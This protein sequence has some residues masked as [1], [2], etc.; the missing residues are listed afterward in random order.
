M[1]A[2]FYVQDNPNL[3]QNCPGEIEVML[4]T[5]GQNILAAD[6]MMT[7]SSSEMTLSNMALGVALPM[8][9]YNVIAAAIL[10]LSGARLPATGSFNGN[11]LY[12]LLT[13]TP[14]AAATSITV[15]FDKSAPTNNVIANETFTNVIDLPNTDGRTI[16]VN[17]RY[18]EEVDGVGFC[19]PDLTPPT[20]NF[21][22]PS[23]GQGGVPVNQPNE[24]F[25]IAD[26][27]A[28]VDI[29]T[30]DY[31]IEGVNYDDT[32]AANTISELGGVHR[33]ETTFTS[34]WTEGQTVNISVYVCD[35]NT[36]PGP[37]CGTTNGTFH[38]YSTPPPSPVCGDGILTYT[39]GEQC[40]DGNNVD[41][42]G[43]SAH[44]FNEVEPVECPDCS[45]CGTCPSAGLVIVTE[46]APPFET[47][48]ISGVEEDEEPEIQEGE[49]PAV[50]QAIRDS[51]PGCT[52]EDIVEDV[53]REFN[54]D[55]RFGTKDARCLEDPEHCMLPFL[56]HS[57]YENV[58][59]NG[60]R[61]YPDVYL[62]GER[63]EP[64]LED[65]SG[66]ISG[67][68][69]EDIHLGTR[70]GMVHGFYED[71][72]NLSPYRPQWNMSRIEII[73]VLNWAVFGQQWKYENEYYA[74]IGGEQNLSSVKKLAADLIEWWHPRYYNLACEK[75]VFSCDPATSFEPDT[76]CSPTWKRD[77]FAR[78]KVFFEGQ[79][80]EVVNPDLDTDKDGIM[81]MDET[82][83][84]LTD[85]ENK[86][87]DGDTLTDGDEVYK[88]KSNPRLMDTDYD[89]LDDQDEIMIHKTSP[90]LPD[91]DGDEYWDDVEIENG[92]DPLDPNSHPQDLNGNGI[93]DEWELRYGISPQSGNDDTDGDG[94]SDLWEFKHNTDPT[95]PDTDGD[96][97]SDA[98]EVLLYGSDPL[99]F[100]NLA[101]LGV[102]ITN[103]VDGMTITDSRPFIQG[104]APQE[105]M[106][107][108]VL[109]RNE[110][111][112]EVM[113]GQ[114]TTDVNNA[115]VLT[116]DFDLVDGEFFLLV[117]GL[118]P[119]NK[120]V[121]ESPLIRLTLDSTLQIDSPRPERLSTINITDDIL[122]EGV[123]IEIRDSKP[124]LIGRAGFKNKVIATWQSVVGTSAIV[125]D[126]AGGEFKIS[127]PKELPFGK[128]TVTVYSVRESD[129]AVSKTV[130]LNFEVKEPLSGILRGVAFGEEL[131]FPVW[132]WILIF[133]GAGGIFMYGVWLDRKRK[134]KK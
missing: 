45:D 37:N 70:Q 119:K 31:T 87:T 116:P 69:K 105:G 68:A 107:V 113:L 65:D 118:D 16:T 58:D 121:L 85:F 103:L 112:H 81:D 88:Y 55:T 110:F 51:I 52:R 128:H 82:N 100:T 109:L 61:Y 114:V 22:L 106:E 94:L 96:G 54:V 17:D 53:V 26:N 76:V 86:D 131:I 41:G 6:A 34:E 91:T 102:R 123:S 2:R 97:L 29:T 130:V 12:G 84:F 39:N 44:C 23:N 117:K 9:T 4:D 35:N 80:S 19:S 15:D 75:G 77:I 28:G 73:K 90:I 21:I 133:L 63:S 66:A 124:I 134:G 60:D 89:N 47:I 43:C 129:Q 64:L 72:P 125:A 92:F 59:P 18:N 48:D 104:F 7:Y 13:V 49:Y 120:R 3:R 20:V 101:D 36:D 5:Q 10:E 42:D 98:D 62:S 57:A 78:Y 25:S 33:V 111:G 93:W 74:E 27:R 32:S 24:I 38:I 126:L 83:I 99:T 40:D 95:N 132:L 115:W 67:P 71:I 8:Q 14:D 46:T 122:L 108:E 11:G 50:S 30:L 127:A 79:K 56:I 1:A